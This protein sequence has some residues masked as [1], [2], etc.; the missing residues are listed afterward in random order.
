M[1]ERRMS[2]RSV[3]SEAPSDG[4]VDAPAETEFMGSLLN[5]DTLRPQLQSTL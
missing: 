1:H 3:Q 4:D 5:E 2:G